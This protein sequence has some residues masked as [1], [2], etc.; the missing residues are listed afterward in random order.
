M[1]G[2]PGCG[3]S[4]TQFCAEAVRL[5]A[6]LDAVKIR[7]RLSESLRE[8]LQAALDAANAAI[9][10]AN[11]RNTAYL[12][13]AESIQSKLQAECDKLRADRERLRAM[14][15]GWMYAYACNCA[16]RGVDIR[17]VELPLIADECLAALAKWEGQP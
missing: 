9:D 13:A 1:T 6:E 10:A 8:E 3:Q 5:Q 15:F 4:T 17:K 16:D 11:A 14:A 7:T 2:C 12:N